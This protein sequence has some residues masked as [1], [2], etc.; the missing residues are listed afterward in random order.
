LQLLLWFQFIGATVSAADVWVE[1]PG[2]MSFFSAKAWAWSLPAAVW[3]WA[4][5]TS[6]TQWRWEGCRTVGVWK[7]WL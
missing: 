6:R 5:V 1:R 4:T 2:L 7:G 3:Q